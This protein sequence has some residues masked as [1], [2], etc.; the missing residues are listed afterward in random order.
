MT[1]RFGLSPDQ[2]KA[3]T[4][5]DLVRGGFDVPQSRVRWALIVLGDL[6]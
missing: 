6:A 3:H 5:L 4:I 1:H 2:R